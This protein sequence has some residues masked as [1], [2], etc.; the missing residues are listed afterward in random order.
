MEWTRYSV[1]SGSREDSRVG[2]NIVDKIVRCGG[3]NAREK[4]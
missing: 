3:G 4:R 1:E 2:N